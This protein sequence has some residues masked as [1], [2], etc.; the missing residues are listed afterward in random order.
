MKYDLDDLITKSYAK[1][2]MVTPEFSQSVMEK[3]QAYSE[4][5]QRNHGRIIVAACVGIACVIGVSILVWGDRT[6]RESD[7]GSSVLAEA[8]GTPDTVNENTD[9]DTEETEHSP[10]VAEKAEQPDN[11][12]EPAQSVPQ[13]SSGEE[14]Q[15]TPAAAE[16]GAPQNKH[17]DNRSAE[18]NK[19]KEDA[20]KSHKD[21]K[22]TVKPNDAKEQTH[23]SGED[24][25]NTINQSPST[26]TQ[27]PNTDTEQTPSASAEPE[28][29]VP[30]GSYLA[31]CSMKC[32]SPN[33]D[34]HEEGQV[35]SEDEGTVP[36]EGEEVELPEGEEN[37][38][39]AKT[40]GLEVVFSRLFS[41]DLFR[42]QKISS[43]EQLQGLIEKAALENKDQLYGEW[44]ME[45]ISQQF[46]QYDKAF[47]EENTLYL[48]TIYLTYGYS[49]SLSGV[50][51]SQD[52]DGN[53]CL[54]IQVDQYKALEPGADTLEVMCYYCCFIQVPKYVANACDSVEYVVTNQRK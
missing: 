18:G 48:Y 46:S 3:M 4:T 24:R 40:E 44:G 39:F 33:K 34:L 28:Q 27:T 23:P 11:S 50:D 10:E 36:P 1:K 21:P 43:Y 13:E 38:A 52:A 2:D 51:V 12:E 17:T 6:N 54:N 32:A 29:K 19:G 16:T 47:F 14:Q 26:A 45:W 5:P 22:T 42:E 9:T 7:P 49:F 31:L 41:G 8:T 25:E 37:E 20:R 15:D 35:P 30:V 53:E